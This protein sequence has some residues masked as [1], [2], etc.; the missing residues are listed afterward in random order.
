MSSSAVKMIESAGTPPLIFRSRPVLR[1]AASPARKVDLPMP[2]APANRERLLSGIQP[3]K[4]HVIGTISTSL[5]RVP[6]RLL[7]EPFGLPAVAL[8]P[9]D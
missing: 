9:E 5:S 3:S 8:S 6:L 4:S 2:P 1:I 7:L